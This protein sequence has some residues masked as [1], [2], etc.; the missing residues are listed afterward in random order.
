MILLPQCLSC[1]RGKIVSLRM[2]TN[3]RLADVRLTTAE[4]RTTGQ[5]LPSDLYPYAGEGMGAGAVR[6]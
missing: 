3:L 6:T 4:Q 1:Y 2:L 5:N